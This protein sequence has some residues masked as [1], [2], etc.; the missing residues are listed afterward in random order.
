MPPH[1]PPIQLRTK[2][3]VIKNIIIVKFPISEINKFL[4]NTVGGLFIVLND[5]VE[6]KCK[7]L[8]WIEGKAIVT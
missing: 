6:R 7:I 3:K 5:L 4:I 8:T 1:M 2:N